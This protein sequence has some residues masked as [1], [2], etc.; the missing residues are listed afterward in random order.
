MKISCIIVDDEPLARKGL[1]EYLQDIPYLQHVGS[2]E[3]ALMAADYLK[4]HTADLMLLDIRMPK[5]SGIDF[6]KTLELSPLIIFT[7][8]STEYAIEGYELNVI[9]YLVKPI[10]FDRFQKATQKAFDLLSLRE[11]ATQSE[12][13][14]FFFIK[15]NH[16]IEKIIYSDVLYIEAMQN[17][18]V[19]HLPN[20][21][22]I[23]YIT[24]LAMMEK[25]PVN[26]FLKV[27]KSFIVA[28]DKIKTI[29]HNEIVVGDV[30]IPVSR[31][32]KQE[33][34]TLVTKN[35]LLKR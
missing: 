35:N 3:N 33:L 22:F 30:S 29:H 12:H 34:I 27:H 5:L 1:F 11:K 10:T 20:Q 9:D 25:L 15:C 31:T 32:L 23:C 4:N 13:E 19:I 17:Y 8:A 6:L 2:F 14:E 21:K 7:T 18:C 28:I 16:K 24:L 26:R